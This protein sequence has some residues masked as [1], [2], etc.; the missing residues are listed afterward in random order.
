MVISG[1]ALRN[2]AMCFL[3]WSAYFWPGRGHPSDGGLGVPEIRDPL[4]RDLS[5]RSRSQCPRERG[6]LCVVGLV[7]A[8]VAVCYLEN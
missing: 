1:R 7:V 8:S 2:T 4:R 5:S 3:A 6:A